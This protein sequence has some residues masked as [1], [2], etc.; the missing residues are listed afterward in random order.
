MVGDTRLEPVTPTVW[1]LH[2]I[3]KNSLISYFFLLFFCQLAAVFQMLSYFRS[4]LA[5]FTAK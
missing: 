2:V 4:F 5:I 1:M 3:L